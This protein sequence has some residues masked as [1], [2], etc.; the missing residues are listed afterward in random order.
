MPEISVGDLTVA[1]EIRGEGPPLL[2]LHGGEG[3]RNSDNHFTPRLEDQFTIITFDQRDAGDTRGADREYDIFHHAQ[4][5]A[6]LLS[7]LG[8]DRVFVY[9]Q[10]YGGL[11]AQA[12]AIAHPNG[13]ERL[14][15]AVT[16]PGKRRRNDQAKVV[17]ALSDAAIGRY[18]PP[19]VSPDLFFAPGAFERRPELRKFLERGRVAPPDAERQRRRALAAESFD[20]LDQLATINAPTLVLGA[21]GDQILDAASSWALAECIPEARLV[22]LEAVGHALTWE[23]PERVA[24]LIRGFLAEHS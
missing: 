10:S 22:V 8:H 16:T 21:W 12:L 15:L 6:G 7:A 11:I 2:M 13:V 23:A 3:D 1:Y 14:V 24:P 4:D 17:L 20:S 18:P 9:G 19:P 5:A